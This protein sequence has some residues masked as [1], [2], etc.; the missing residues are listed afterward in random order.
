[1]STDCADIGAIGAI[2]TVSADSARCAYN[3]LGA[4]ISGCYACYLHAMWA[5]MCAMSAYIA[6]YGLAY[7]A[8]DIACDT[9]LIA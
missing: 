4:A 8:A 2:C 3:T 9:C 7:D 6:C 1:M 5:D